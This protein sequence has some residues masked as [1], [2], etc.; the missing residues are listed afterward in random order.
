MSAIGTTDGEMTIAGLLDSFLR[1]GLPVRFS[2]YDGSEAGP[3]DTQIHL[4]LCN[5][6]GL[7]YLLTHMPP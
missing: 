7:S 3:S 2:A 1:G 6:R 4:E 5:A